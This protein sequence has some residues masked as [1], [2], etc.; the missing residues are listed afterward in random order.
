MADVF[1]AHA[2]ADTMLVSVCKKAIEDAGFSHFFAEFVMEGRSLPDK[3]RDNIR[4]SR[5]VV[6]LWTRN[7]SDVSRTRDIVN[8]EI[9]E[10]HMAAKPVYVFREEGAEVPNFLANIM[11][12]FTFKP[13][14]HND[15]LDKLRKVLDRVGRKIDAK[16]QEEL[17]DGTLQVKNDK[18]LVFTLSK[19]DIVE[20]MM[21]EVDRQDFACYIMTERNYAE[22]C[23][24]RGKGTIEKSFL[25]QSSYS[26]KWKMTLF[27]GA[28]VAQ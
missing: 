8:A 22:S 20:G 23:D 17:F 19:G 7:V 9:G 10:A 18:A 27:C 21:K 16:T 11:D 14:E 28:D 2:S 12:Y 3:I 4:A 15:V 13:G 6:V 1:V 24:D 25:G 5:I 26:V